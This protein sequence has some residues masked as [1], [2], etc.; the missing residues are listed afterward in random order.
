M[1]ILNLSLKEGID[2]GNLCKRLQ[3]EISKHLRAEDV[4]RKTI[5]VHLDDI[6]DSQIHNSP[7]RIENKPIR[8]CGTTEKTESL[9]QKEQESGKKEQNS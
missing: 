9:R 1:I 8:R 7:Q 5:T 3:D 4:D 2:C 6:I